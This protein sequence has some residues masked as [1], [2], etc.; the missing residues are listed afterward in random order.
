VERLKE[1]DLQWLKK[2]WETVPYSST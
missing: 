2:H 1:T